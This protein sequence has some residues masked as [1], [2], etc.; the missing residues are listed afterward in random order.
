MNNQN[1]RETLY[2]LSDWIMRLIYL[3]LL[4]IAFTLLGLVLF[5]WAPASI[6]AQ[7]ILRKWMISEQPFNT[8]QF[9]WKTYRK[10]FMNSQKAN[11]FILFTGS[12]LIIDLAF[13]MSGHT[14]LFILGRFFTAQLIVVF[15]V[16]CLYS[17]SFYTHF[18]M[19]YFAILKTSIKLAIK[20]PLNT[21]L[22]LLGLLSLYCVL[23]LVPGLIALCGSSVLGLWCMNR[24]MRVL[25]Q[26]QAVQN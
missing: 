4:W 5:G 23:Y 18:Q 2:H 7:T 11:G 17:F 14:H 19:S 6:A 15:I 21:I 24:S 22:T 10:E 16:I 25:N 1:L 9:F 20:H 26:S 3:N 12:L 8:L 13:F